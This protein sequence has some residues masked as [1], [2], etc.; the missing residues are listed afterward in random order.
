M[1]LL[2]RPTHSHMPARLSLQETHLAKWAA[3]RLWPP[4]VTRRSHR[5]GGEAAL[6]PKC[7]NH[8]S[9]WMML[10]CRWARS[11]LP[12]GKLK[13]LY[14][15]GDSSRGGNSE[16]EVVKMGEHSGF[17]PRLLMDDGIRHHR[18]VRWAPL[19]VLSVC[20]SW[21]TTELHLCAKDEAVFTLLSPLPA[22][23]CFYNLVFID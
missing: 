12:F 22:C 16:Q 8:P 13:R 1:S 2:P 14:L 9:T 3:S 17:E 18:L 15:E 4:S 7:L 19:S 5:G 23:C 21:V 20:K 10:T 11:E 6:S